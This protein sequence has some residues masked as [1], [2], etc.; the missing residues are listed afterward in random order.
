[1]MPVPRVSLDQQQESQTRVLID[2]ALIDP[3]RP[4][5]STNVT[6]KAV[7]DRF[8]AIIDGITGY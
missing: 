3:D 1:M 5:S 2:K 7:P 6:I 4:L 8:K